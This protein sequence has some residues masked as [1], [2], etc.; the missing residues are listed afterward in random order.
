M[1]KAWLLSVRDLGSKV[2]DE[3]RE[4]V[5]S[6]RVLSLRQRHTVVVGE[7]MEVQRSRGKVNHQTAGDVRRRISAFGELRNE[8]VYVS[9][10]TRQCKC[11]PC[12]ADGPSPRSNGREPSRR[13]RVYISQAAVGDYLGVRETG[14]G[15]STRCL[16]RVQKKKIIMI[17]SRTVKVETGRVGRN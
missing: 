6:N 4:N 3:E 9:A 7:G 17:G 14:L 16:S 8:A 10:G 1:K 12:S 11:A 13:W 5:R 15:L 2:L